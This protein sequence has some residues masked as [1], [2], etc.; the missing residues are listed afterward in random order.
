[1]EENRENK[2]RLV[3]GGISEDIWCGCVCVCEKFHVRVIFKLGMTKILAYQGEG[4][5]LTRVKDKILAYQGEGLDI[6]LLG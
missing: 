5:Q 6:S 3:S 2:P 1:M 4:S